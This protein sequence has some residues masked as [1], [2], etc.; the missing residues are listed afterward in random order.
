M[1]AADLSWP[2]D[3]SYKL[4]TPHTPEEDLAVAQAEL[5]LAGARR[6]RYAILPGRSPAILQQLNDEV[7]AAQAKCD[8]MRE[9]LVVQE[10]T[11]GGDGGDNQ[12]EQ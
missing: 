4:P 6:G 11:T 7:T 3:A 2:E 8:A 12:G 5:A 1:N 9:V 10:G